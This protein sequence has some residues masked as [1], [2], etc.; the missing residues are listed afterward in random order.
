MFLFTYVSVAKYKEFL[1]LFS[2][3]NHKIIG[4]FLRSCLGLNTVALLTSLRELTDEM[5]E[6]KSSSVRS[7]FYEQ[8]LVNKIAANEAYREKIDYGI[9]SNDFCCK[10]TIFF[11]EAQ[12]P[13]NMIFFKLSIT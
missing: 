4:E 13:E 2:L 1:F 12:M 5:Y 6:R 8:L 11:I 3:K 7:F 9:A 10:I